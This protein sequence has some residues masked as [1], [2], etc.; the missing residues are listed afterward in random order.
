MK[1]KRNSHHTIDCLHKAKTQGFAYLTPDE[2]RL[3]E[4]LRRTTH[5]G[6][7]I[8]YTLAQDLGRARPWGQRV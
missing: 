5:A 3:I 4:T 2:H 8:I 1:S 6:R 7:T